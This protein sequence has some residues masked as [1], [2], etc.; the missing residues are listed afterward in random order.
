MEQNFFD[1]IYSLYCP[2]LTETFLDA[3]SSSSPGP[4]HRDSGLE[5]LAHL[6]S[7]FGWLETLVQVYLEGK[8]SSSMAAAQ[9][10]ESGG[11]VKNAQKVIRKVLEYF[12]FAAKVRSA[13]L[14]LKHMW[15]GLL[16]A[17]RDTFPL[18]CAFD[19]SIVHHKYF[20][21]NLDSKNSTYSTKNRIYSEGC[22]LDNV[23]ISW[24]HDDYMYLVAKEH[25]TTLPP[26]AFKYDLYSKSKVYIDVEKVKPYYLSLIEKVSTILVRKLGV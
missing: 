1:L 18:G 11:D 25:G 23:M 8:D 13:L 10:V 7:I 17:S 14:S 15:V 9:L 3:P 16:V 19:E 5:V 22:G 4:R 2:G 24:G 21:Y 26:A 12:A 20:G 6:H